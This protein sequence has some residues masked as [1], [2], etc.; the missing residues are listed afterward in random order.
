M[1]QKTINVTLAVTY[2]YDENGSQAR[3]FEGIRDCNAATDK[4][5]EY[6]DHVRN[7][8]VCRVVDDVAAHMHTIENGIQIDN[9]WSVEDFE[10]EQ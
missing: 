2:S 10:V 7:Q 6:A 9:V 4:T 3:E 5:V 8:V 1:I